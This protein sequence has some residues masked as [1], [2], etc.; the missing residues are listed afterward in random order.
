M[1]SYCLYFSL[2]F[3]KNSRVLVLVSQIVSKIGTRSKDVL[4]T[5]IFLMMCVTPSHPKSPCCQSFQLLLA[6]DWHELLSWQNWPVMADRAPVSLVRGAVSG[7]DVL[8]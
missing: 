2:I 1:Q 6:P 4:Y 8:E 3:F 5:F 7:G